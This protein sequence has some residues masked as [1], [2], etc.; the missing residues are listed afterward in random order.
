MDHNIEINWFEGNDIMKED[1]LQHRIDQEEIH[2]N[3]GDEFLNTFSKR[4][5]IRNTNYEGLVEDMY[6]RALTRFKEGNLKRAEKQCMQ[7]F[8]LI[9]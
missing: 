3:K 6:L 7:A 5:R 9:N 8:S 2:S 4:R 1:Q